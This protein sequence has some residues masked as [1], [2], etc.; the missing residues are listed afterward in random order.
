MDST[1]QLRG[2][3][4]DEVKSAMYR[5]LIQANGVPA[6][7]GRLKI[8][9]HFVAEIFDHFQAWAMAIGHSF[10]WCSITAEGNMRLFLDLEVSFGVGVVFHTSCKLQ[11]RSPTDPLSWSK[12]RFLSASA[13]VPSRAGGII[14]LNNRVCADAA[15]FRAFAAELMADRLILEQESFVIRKVGGA[16]LLKY[17]TNE[18]HQLRP[19][20]AGWC[21]KHGLRL[22]SLNEVQQNTLEGISR[23][24]CSICG[25]AVD[26]L[27]PIPEKAI[28]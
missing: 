18:S 26:I 14:S 9:Q 11:Q 13:L 3:F 4:M 22:K 17:I 20:E 16:A 5:K 6:P 15:A 27:R 8:E 23:D 2:A 25:S 19:M 7:C 21:Q 1:S 10:T 24:T 12:T 28:A